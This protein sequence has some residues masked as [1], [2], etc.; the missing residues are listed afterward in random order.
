[1]MKKVAEYRVAYADTD[2]M[3]FV[4]YGNYLVY[5]E[6]TRTELMRQQGLTYR[7]L[8]AMGIALP[9]IE[10]HLKY[11]APAHYDDVL[12][13]HGRVT[14]LQG[15]RLTIACEVRRGDTLLAEG[16]TTLAFMDAA[17]GRPK[18]IADDL[19]QRIEA[20]IAAEEQA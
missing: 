4:Y 16:Y 18:R 13:F 19:R 14:A 5:F 17:T 3:G 12:S 2:K 7:E 11:H 6:R 15:V 1:M 8:E 9:V 10:A 20:V